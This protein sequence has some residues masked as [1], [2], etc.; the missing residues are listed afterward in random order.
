MNNP[1]EGMTGRRWSGA[2]PYR[3][4][5]ACCGIASQPM[6]QGLHVA[7]AILPA[8]FSANE[9]AVRRSMFFSSREASQ[10]TDDSKGER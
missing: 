5:S 8:H 9:P 2:H 1:S 10:E 3:P 6:P 4:G 7:D